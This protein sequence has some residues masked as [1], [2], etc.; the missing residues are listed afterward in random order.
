MSELT[1]ATFEM[2]ICVRSAH[3]WTIGCSETKLGHRKT[4]KFA[5]ACLLKIQL[6][7]SAAVGRVAEHF[8]SKS[9]M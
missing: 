5:M 2:R 1:V 9:R 3:A 6:A 8:E 7:L 4:L